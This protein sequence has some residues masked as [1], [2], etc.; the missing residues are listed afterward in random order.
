MPKARLHSSQRTRLFS[1]TNTERNL[2]FPAGSL[3]RGAR[4]ASTA[5]D[6]KGGPALTPRAARAARVAHAA[7]A[8]RAARAEK[9][10]TRKRGCAAVWHNR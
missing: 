10:S 2:T 6:D 1:N 7:R 4:A 9:S 8:A 3:G 5:R